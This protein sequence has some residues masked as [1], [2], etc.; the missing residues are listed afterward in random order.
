[1]IEKHP[2]PLQARARNLL[3][4]APLV[5]SCG[6]APKPVAAAPRLVEPAISPTEELSPP[7]LTIE[8]SNAAEPES[9][10]FPE[11]CGEGAGDDVCSPPE[12]FTQ[13]MCGG[14]AKPALA[15]R[16]FANGSPWTRAYLRGNVDAWHAGAHSAR[17]TLKFDEEVIVLSHR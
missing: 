10:A 14:Y 7:P 8:S 3:L 17:V 4:L 16:L 6:S 1:M 9:L 5:A 12:E 2:S 11:R 13:E 15:L